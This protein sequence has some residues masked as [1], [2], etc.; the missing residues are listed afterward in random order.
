MS[1]F[2]DSAHPDDAHAAMALGYIRGITTNPALIAR[3]G[4]P[5]LDLLAELCSISRGPVFFQLAGETPDARRAEALAARDVDPDKVVLKVPTTPDNLTLVAELSREHPCAM[6]AIFNAAQ[7]YVAAQVGARY[8]IPYVNRSTRLLGDG[9]ELVREM[10]AVLD[11][12]HT[13]IIAASIKSPEEAVAA[14]LAGAHHLTVPL[15]LLRELGH[16]DLSEAAIAEF[17]AALAEVKLAT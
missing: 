3:T 9:P 6:T 14:L 16:H 5:P 4:H 15:K 11:G 17:A 8:V 13:E 1:L 10:T 2:L 7:A 12:T